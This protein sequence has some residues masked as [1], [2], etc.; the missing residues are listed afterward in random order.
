M[1]DFDSQQD[2]DNGYAKPAGPLVQYIG[3]LIGLVIALTLMW[4]AMSRR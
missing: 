2:E 4:W 1:N 3:S